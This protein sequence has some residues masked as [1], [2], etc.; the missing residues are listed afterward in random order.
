MMHFWMYSFYLFSKW[1]M[2]KNIPK[3]AV[4]RVICYTDMFIFPGRK[5][6]NE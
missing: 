1:Y 4:V 6:C 3:L 2:W 5:Y